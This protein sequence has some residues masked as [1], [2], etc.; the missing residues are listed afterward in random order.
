M[1]HILAETHSHTQNIVLLTESLCYII[2]GRGRK[3]QRS[4]GSADKT[5][6]NIDSR[7]MSDHNPLYYNSTC[8][9]RFTG[10]LGIIGPMRD[11]SVSLSL[12]LSQSWAP[13]MWDARPL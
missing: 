11:T 10:G 5:I 2:I 12:S 4:V 6:R 9:V 3:G 1:Q 13:Q 7:F 8:R